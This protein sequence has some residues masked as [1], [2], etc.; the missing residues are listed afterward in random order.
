MER[1]PDKKTRMKNE[2]RP[3][4]GKTVPRRPHAVSEVT[5]IEAHGGTKALFKR[6]RVTQG[7][8]R[9]PEQVRQPSIK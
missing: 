5:V 3:K 9:P 7:A 1:I 8:R 6:A 4:G 2:K